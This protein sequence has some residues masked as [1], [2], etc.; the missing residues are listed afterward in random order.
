MTDPLVLDM[1]SVERLSE[2]SQ[3]VQ[4]IDAFFGLCAA[5]PINSAP[6]IRYPAYQETVWYSAVICGMGWYALNGPQTDWRANALDQLFGTFD[7][8]DA[9]ANCVAPLAAI[10]QIESEIQAAGGVASDYQRQTLLARITA[11]SQWLSQ[12]SQSLSQGFANLQRLG[13]QAVQQIHDGLVKD[14]AFEEVPPLP[15]G[16]PTPYL[17]EHKR[18]GAQL[19]NMAS[20]LNAPSD[21]L[22][23]AWTAMQKMV[24]DIS[25]RIRAAGAADIGGVLQQLNVQSSLQQWPLLCSM[26][27]RYRPGPR[28]P[29]PPPPAGFEPIA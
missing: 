17:D 22:I 3:A 4:Q 28:P 18:V 19:I 5:M 23:V 7:I 20:A 6:I 24:D 12:K 25:A 11:L 10:A 15:G 21:T 27:V 9:S 1:S 29:L 13:I 26:A 2:V 8:E 14:L 16:S